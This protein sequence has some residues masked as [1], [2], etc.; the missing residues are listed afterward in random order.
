MSAKDNDFSGPEAGLS[1]SSAFVPFVRRKNKKTRTTTRS[2]MLRERPHFR[3]AGRGS[4]APLKSD[5]LFMQRHLCY[6]Q[7]TKHQSAAPATS[8]LRDKSFAPAGYQFTFSSTMAEYSA[9]D[10]PARKWKREVRVHEDRG[11]ESGEALSSWSYSD[12]RSRRKQ[13]RPFQLV[14]AQESRKNGFCEV[15]SSVGL[16][17]PT[18]AMLEVL[19]VKEAL[20][21]QQQ[22]RPETSMCKQT[23]EM[24]LDREKRPGSL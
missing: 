16:D 1:V 14:V 3:P 11:S 19:Q 21:E 8:Q 18:P 20:L 17:N 9:A 12:S 4:I 7:M 5:P 6:Y 10:P 23:V 24:H 22:E 2:G 13:S 15:S